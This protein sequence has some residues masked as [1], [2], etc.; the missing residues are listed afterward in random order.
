MKYH[1]V[2]CILIIKDH[3]ED[4]GWN[5]KLEYLTSIDSYTSLMVNAVTPQKY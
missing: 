4:E 3:I 5:N 1:T 2:Y